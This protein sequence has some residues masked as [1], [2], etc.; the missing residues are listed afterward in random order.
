LELAPTD[1]VVVRGS[2]PLGP[3][4]APIPYSWP[5]P[6]RKGAARRVS[7]TRHWR[8]L[9]SITGRID[10]YLRRGR[11]E[12][13]GHEVA[14]W[15]ANNLGL[16]TKQTEMY[17]VKEFLR[18]YAKFLSEINHTSVLLIEID[19]EEVYVGRATPGADDL[20]DALT[21]A[22]EHLASHREENKVLLSTL[23]RTRNAY[24]DSLKITLEAQYNRKHGHGKPGIEVRFLGIP[25]ILLKKSQEGDKD[26]RAR[27]DQLRRQ[28][29][30]VAKEKFARKYENASKVLLKDY[31][32]RLSKF[33]D[34]A[35]TTRW[36]HLEW[37][38][39]GKD[40]KHRVKF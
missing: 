3:Y 9:S 24:R 17:D 21:M 2:G 27:I 32:R 28:L 36:L 31:E 7:K 14:G 20:N 11:T 16:F 23:G 15:F 35:R 22:S 33:F 8:L 25:S 6:A 13:P 39:T 5:Y 34:A 12:R 19:Y 26:Y 29:T 18:R 10:I 30:N 37:G 38:K 1:E 40:L 4:W